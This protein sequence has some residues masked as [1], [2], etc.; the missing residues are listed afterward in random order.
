MSRPE[1]DIIRAFPRERTRRGDK[2]RRR[3]DFECI[4]QSIDSSSTIQPR[5]KSDR[6]RSRGWH[7]V[8]RRFC[9][10]TPD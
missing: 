10:G 7:R 4:S 8:T 9:S 6:L 3:L 2:V 5:A 1:A